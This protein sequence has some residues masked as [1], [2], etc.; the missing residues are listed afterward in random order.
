[1]RIED[2]DRERSTQEAVDAI[3]HAMDWLGLEYDEGPIYQTER[4]GRYQEVAE[5]MVAEGKASEQD[6]HLFQVVDDVDEAVALIRST[7]ADR[8]PLRQE[9]LDAVMVKEEAERRAASNPLMGI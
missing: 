2:T 4:L 8:S 7:E 9:E 1:M 5:R 3:L 6:L